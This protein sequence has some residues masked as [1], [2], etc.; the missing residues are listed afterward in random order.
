MMG[1]RRGYLR[2]V[3]LPDQA[4]SPVFLLCDGFGSLCL[5]SGITGAKALPVRGSAAAKMEVKIKRWLESPGRGSPRFH[6]LESLPRRGQLFCVF[7]F[8]NGCKYINDKA[9][10][11]R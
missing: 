6:L 1:R 10:L 9:Y 5:A 2:H 3:N 8:H 4:P 7:G 11:E